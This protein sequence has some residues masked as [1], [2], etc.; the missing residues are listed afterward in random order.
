MIENLIVDDS[1]LAFILESPY[2]NEVEKGYPLAG[3]SGKEIA[4]RLLGKEGISLGEICNNKDFLSNQ[5]SPF[6]ILNISRF[7]LEINAYGSH[8]L[9]NNFA[10]MDSLKRNIDRQYKNGEKHHEHWTEPRNAELEKLKNELLNELTDNLNKLFQINENIHLVPCGKLARIFVRQALK[11]KK[12]A[13]KCYVHY[14]LPH[15][16]RNQWSNVPIPILDELKA[17]ITIKP[18]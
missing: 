18:A 8:P 2:A 3:D 4:Y 9:P 12:L 10:I 6:S 1:L 16:A 11:N 14:D 17:L 13:N 7:P 15:P 5:L